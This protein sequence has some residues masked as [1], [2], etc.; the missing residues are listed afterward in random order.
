MHFACHEAK[1]IAW[2]SYNNIES[3]ESRLTATLR[4]LHLRF[5]YLGAAGNRCPCGLEHTR[6]V[7]TEF[8]TALKIDMHTLACDIELTK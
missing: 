4:T 8:R 7:S 1:P 6:R 3:K 5:R 2:K